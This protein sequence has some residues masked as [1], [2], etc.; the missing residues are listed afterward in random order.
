MNGKLDT[1]VLG[2]TFNF[3]KHQS[4]KAKKCEYNKTIQ[5]EI[6]KNVIVGVYSSREKTYLELHF[7]I[8][9]LKDKH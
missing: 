6:A 2:E 1:C 9:M 4:L 3:L 8:I 5:I 7:F